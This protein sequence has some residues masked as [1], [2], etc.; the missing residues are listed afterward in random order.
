[1]H[2]VPLAHEQVGDEVLVERNSA[3]AFAWDLAPPVITPSG[4]RQPERSMSVES[5]AHETKS[6]H[7][8]K[9]DG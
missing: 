3:V 1:V 2:N 6:R 9:R 7:A 5:F 8:V 4:Q